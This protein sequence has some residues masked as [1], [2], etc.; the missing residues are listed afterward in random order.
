MKRSSTN[1]PLRIAFHCGQ[2]TAGG[3]ASF[4]RQLSIKLKEIGHQPVLLSNGEGAF[5]NEMRQVSECFVIEHQD[6]IGHGINVAGIRIP[7]PWN[8]LMKVSGVFRSNPSIEKTLR[9]AK[10]DVVIGCGQYSAA[11]IGRACNRTSI[12]LITCIH[13]IG[14]RTN[15]IGRLRAR[16]SAKLFNRSDC[17]VGVSNACLERYLSFLEVP[18]RTI[19]NCCPPILKRHETKLAFHQKHGLSDQTVVIGSIGRIQADKGLHILVQAFSLL[20]DQSDL[21]LAIAGQPLT[22]KERSYLQQLKALA[23][24]VGIKDRC[25]FIGHSTPADFFSIA[26]MFCHTYLGEEALSYAI[27]ESMSAG[28]PVIASNSGGPKEIIEQGKSGQ[29]VEANNPE[30]LANAMKKYLNDPAFVREATEASS[31]IIREKFNYENWA[32]QWIDAIE[33]GG[34]SR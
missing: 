25:H 29:L 33:N 18:S 24:R 27:L 13:G 28:C 15:D 34:D 2:E 23:D 22:E 32:S 3:L 12:P 5:Y 8:A 9:N 7:N 21:A 11:S 4:I 31:R 10:P 30:I 26:D 17:V 1:N 16:F 6:V 19:Y 20:N 14:K